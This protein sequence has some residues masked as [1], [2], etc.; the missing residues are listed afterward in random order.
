MQQLTS[1]INLIAS[2]GINLLAYVHTL[3]GNFPTHAIGHHV[4]V[5]TTYNN[6]FCEACLL[7]LSSCCLELSTE[8]CHQLRL[9]YCF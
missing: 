7:I 3:K 6:D 2:A 5:S 9:C 4:T 8:N 1:G